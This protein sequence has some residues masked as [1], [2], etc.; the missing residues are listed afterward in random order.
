MND[1]TPDR[2]AIEKSLRD[3]ARTLES[4]VA[5]SGAIAAIGAAMVAALKAGHKVLTAGN[6]GSAAEALHM[7][8]ELVGR[9]KANRVSL[10]AIALVADCTALTCIGNDYGYDEIFRRQIEGLGNSGDLLVLFSTSGNAENLRL[11]LEEGHRK[12]LVTVA[13]LGRGGGKLAGKATHEI[14][15]PGQ[16]TARIQEAHQVIL[17][18][19]LEIVETAFT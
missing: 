12:G 3:S 1:I 13:L 18:I 8:E 11:A 15:V 5:Q 19:L 4:L 16:E 17:H 14:I 10:P 2:H 7:S 6:G 9:F